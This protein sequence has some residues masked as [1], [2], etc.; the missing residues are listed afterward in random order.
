MWDVAKEAGSYGVGN[1]YVKDR[2]RVIHGMNA[3]RRLVTAH[4][5]LQWTND[6]EGCNLTMVSLQK[7]YDNHTSGEWYAN[8]IEE[9]R[10]H[11]TVPVANLE[12]MYEAG[13]LRQCAGSCCNDCA[14]NVSDKATLRHVLWDLYMAGGYG[15]YYDC[16]TGTCTA[17]ASD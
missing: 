3:H 4:S 11:S 9:R 10:K 2:L 8:M 6:C 14:S 5:G 1:A 15:A 12:Y 17:T 16:D 13:H 7:H